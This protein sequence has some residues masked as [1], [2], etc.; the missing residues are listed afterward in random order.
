MFLNN[1]KNVYSKYFSAKDDL[2]YRYKYYG[3]LGYEKDPLA[4]LRVITD[5]EIY[6]SNPC[7]FNDPF[8]CIPIA[9][10]R[11]M[12]RVR[13]FLDDRIQNT[14]DTLDK[15]KANY[16]ELASANTRKVYKHALKTSAENLSTPEAM[17]ALANEFRV[18]CL[19]RDPANFLMWSHYGVSHTGFAVEFRLDSNLPATGSLNTARV[20]YKKGR[21]HI[22]KV[23]SRVDIFN[24]KNPIW[25]YEK[26]ERIVHLGTG[27]TESYHHQQLKSVILGACVDENIEIEVTKAVNQVNATGA[28]PHELKLYRAELAQD[29]YKLYIPDHPYFGNPN[30]KEVP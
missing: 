24:F 5:A 2:M 18:L 16:P 14:P 29:S 1:R 28:L 3:S 15:H 8:D 25:K 13:S 27:E 12:K 11:V 30:F 6:F 21:P 9:K 4:N 10:P 19:C 22:D 23:Q 26:E 17:K 20:Q 7:K